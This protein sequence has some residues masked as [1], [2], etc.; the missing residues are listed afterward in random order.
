MGDFEY[1]FKELLSKEYRAQQIGASLIALALV[2]TFNGL[3][4]EP[5]L[6]LLGILIFDLVLH[7]KKKDTILILTR[8]PQVEI[9]SMEFIYKIRNCSKNIVFKIS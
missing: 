4:L 6:V 3:I 8:N 2:L 5:L 7:F 9:N 1:N